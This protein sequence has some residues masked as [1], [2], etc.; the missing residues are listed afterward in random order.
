MTFYDALF[1]LWYH[2]LETG[3]MDKEVKSQ[4]DGVKAQ[5]TTFSF[6]FV[7]RL[8]YRL[9]AIPDKL[10]KSLHKKKMSARV[11]EKPK[12]GRKQ[13]KLKYYILKYVDGYNKCEAY[14][15]EMTKD[16]FQ[17]IYFESIDYFVVSL[18]ERFE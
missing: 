5:M 15:P 9:Y 14:H 8:G 6:F 13:P 12:K 17:Q 16:Q 1:S 7:L 4:I 3:K 2:Y 10:S 18:K 11:V